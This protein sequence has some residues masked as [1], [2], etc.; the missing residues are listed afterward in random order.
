[1]HSALAQ[2]E[3]DADCTDLVSTTVTLGTPYLGAPLERGADALARHAAKVPPARWLAELVT[4]RSEGIKNLGDGLGPHSQ[5]T[6]DAEHARRHYL[7]FATLVPGGAGRLR[8][9]TGDVIV[10][11]ASAAGGYELPFADDERACVLHLPGHHHMDLLNSPVL[12]EHLLG[13]LTNDVH[14]E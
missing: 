11:T 6:Q 13:W 3:S 8:D 9:L 14:P 10:P 1:M 7:V 12:Y 5:L 4:A 2:R